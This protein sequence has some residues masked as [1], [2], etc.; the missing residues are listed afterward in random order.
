MWHFEFKGRGENYAIINFLA[1]LIP[2]TIFSPLKHLINLPST[3]TY[4]DFH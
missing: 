1:S 4:L 2:I 3:Q